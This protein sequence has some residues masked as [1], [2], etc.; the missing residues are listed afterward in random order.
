MHW[1]GL[2]YHVVVYM[3]VIWFLNKQ[4]AAGQKV[5]SPGLCE[6]ASDVM[7]VSMFTQFLACFTGW[8]NYFLLVIPGYGLY[9]CGQYFLNWI[10]T[11]DPEPE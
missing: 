3:V 8:G 1:V 10:F 11:P 4:A 6:A 5:T 9:L 7:Y 2:V